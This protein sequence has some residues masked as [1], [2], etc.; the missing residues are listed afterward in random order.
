MARLQE[1]GI[2]TYTRR[3]L[4]ATPSYENR[5]RG[6]G[7]TGLDPNDPAGGL[8]MLPGQTL[9]KR[10][11]PDPQQRERQGPMVEIAQRLMDKGQKQI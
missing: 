3:E 6:C 7:G 1:N 10:L 2:I 5:D 9:A 11:F 8:G 4:A